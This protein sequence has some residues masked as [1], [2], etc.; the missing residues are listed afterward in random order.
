M[1]SLLETA[2]VLGTTRYGPQGVETCIVRHRWQ[3]E[4]LEL[5]SIGCVS[6]LEAIGFLLLA[7]AFGHKKRS[8]M[9]EPM[10]GAARLGARDRKRLCALET[11]VLWALANSSWVAECGLSKSC[12][13][14]CS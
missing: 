4:C 12:E 5:V 9:Y 2:G 10:L 3:Q 7:F 1:L 11:Q 6:P 14:E 13:Y 8:L